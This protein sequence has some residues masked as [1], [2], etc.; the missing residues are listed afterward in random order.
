MSVDFSNVK[1]GDRIK[2]TRENGD[3]ST[4]TVNNLIRELAED[5]K[6]T[7]YYGDEWDTLEILEKPL[8]TNENAMIGHPTDRSW[9]PYILQSGT[10]M[11]PGHG[12]TPGEDHIRSMIREEG[13]EVL[14]EGIP[15][16]A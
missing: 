2:L 4:I 11:Q 3:E 1:V 14:Y 16:D 13:F 15:A 6:S 5:V 10:W 12:N 7:A 9:V 8:P